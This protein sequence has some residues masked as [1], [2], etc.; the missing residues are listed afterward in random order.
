MSNKKCLTCGGSGVIQEYD[1]FDDR[2]VAFRCPQC[3]GSGVINDNELKSCPFCGGEAETVDW[4]NHY[5]QFFFVRCKTCKSQTKL[6]S[7]IEEAIKA[8]NRRKEE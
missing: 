4:D 1:D 3:D 6:F 2:Y 8:W 7:Y 5:Y